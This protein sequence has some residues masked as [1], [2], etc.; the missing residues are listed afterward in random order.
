MYDTGSFV[1]RLSMYNKKKPKQLDYYT[2]LILSNE[3]KHE[4]TESDSD[5]DDKD[6]GTACRVQEQRCVLHDD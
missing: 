1:A 2:L 5:W 6:E 4:M 3:M